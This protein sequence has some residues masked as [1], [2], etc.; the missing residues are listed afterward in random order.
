M[1]FDF[2]TT[3]PDPALQLVPISFPIPLAAQIGS[4][5]VHSV[6]VGGPAPA[7]CTGGTVADPKADPGHICVYARTFTNASF[8]TFLSPVVRASGEFD[9]GTDTSG[10]LVVLTENGPGALAHGT[11]AVTAP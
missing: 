9:S 11:W 5:G 6:P 4:T 2:D 1:D 3:D 7:G 8:S 10:A